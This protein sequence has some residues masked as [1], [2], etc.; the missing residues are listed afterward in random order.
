[1]SNAASRI[2]AIPQTAGA[3]QSGARMAFVD[4]I[5]WMV[6]AMVVLVHA[7]V[8]YS[9]LGSWYYHENVA[10]DVASKLV[11]YAYEIFSQGFFMGILFFI[12]AAFIPG[13]YDRKGFRK[14]IT[15]RLVR[16]GLPTLVFMLVLH[17]LTMYILAANGAAL[18][19][20]RG[21]W[22]WY[23]SL[24]TSGRFLSE[25][26]PLWFAF[27]LLAFSILYAV[28][29]WVVDK[30]RTPTTDNVAVR[31]VT[32]KAV[33]LAAVL[34]MLVIALGSFFVR[35]VQPIGTS[36]LNMQ[37]CFFPQYIVLFGAG[38]WA[39]RI[40]LLQS[41]PRAA[42]K[43]W[44]R[45]AFALGV[46]GWFLLMGL[47]GAISGSETV[48]AGGWHWQAAA[49]AAWEG[50]FSVSISLGLITLFREKGNARTPVTGLLADTC[51]GIYVF[52]TP[53][54]VAA[55]M[56]IQ[57]LALYPLAKALLAGV[58]AWVVTLAVAWLVRRIPF[59]G[60]IFA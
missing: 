56:A 6:I 49:F 46:P 16:L 29:R 8:T 40:G 5:R 17:P 15:D 45:L 23:G 60:R 59:I 41:L 32:T 13:A 9:G 25:S 48:F 28:G 18:L 47:G 54:L 58:A 26:G 14:F 21:F 39:G 3:P 50:F 33:H 37:L 7:C 51:F 2:G 1:M 20:S 35:L 12:A 19:G 57:A 22:A 44:L 55:S 11:F 34:L 43:V 42:G 38:L 52:H 31:P 4:N 36:W 30:L 10:L 27:A 53:V 24:L